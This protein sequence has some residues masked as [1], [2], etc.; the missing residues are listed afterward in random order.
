MDTDIIFI[1]K[2]EEGKDIKVSNSNR[3][4]QKGA[5][6]GNEITV[7]V[8]SVLFQMGTVS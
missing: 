3:V 7:M 1:I 2:D 6:P 8:L 5:M 4:G